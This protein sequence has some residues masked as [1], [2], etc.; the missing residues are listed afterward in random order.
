MKLRVFF[1]FLIL[2]ASFLIFV[3]T[4][5]PDKENLPIQN[6]IP[7]NFAINLEG[8]QESTVS[9]SVQNSEDFS[10][11][12]GAGI[13]WKIEEANTYIATCAHLFDEQANQKIVIYPFGL[14]MK[15]YGESAELIGISENYDIALLK[16][17]NSRSHYLS[18]K[19][20]EDAITGKLIFALGNPYGKGGAISLGIL[21]LPYEEIDNMFLHRIDCKLYPGNSGGGVFDAD[22]NVLGMITHKVLN[23]TDNSEFGYAIPFSALN[24]LANK[25]LNNEECSQNQNAL[26]FSFQVVEKRKSDDGKWIETLAIT[27]IGQ[28]NQFSIGDRIIAIFIDEQ[29]YP[30]T[31]KGQLS[32]MLMTLSSSS[33][34]SIIL[35]HYGDPKIVPIT[36]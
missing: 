12:I 18:A 9:I 20:S 16:I 4:R 8:A 1:L 14:E 26:S 30:I 6:D 33:K 24:I 23:K 36:L 28:N 25:I 34:I 13:V 19:P 11:Q 10:V 21:S 15:Q 5:P 31:S 17:Q 29:I 3:K 2:L 32:I 35:A 27:K 22:G 7:I